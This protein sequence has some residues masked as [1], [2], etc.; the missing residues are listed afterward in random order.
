MHRF[1]LQVLRRPTRNDVADLDDQIAAF[2]CDAT[3]AR[4]DLELGIFVRGGD[5]SLNVDDEP[6]S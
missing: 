6:T 5:G 1:E 3:N 2:N 4:D